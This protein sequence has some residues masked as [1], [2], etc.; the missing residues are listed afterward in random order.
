MVNA[1][2]FATE[3]EAN[4]KKI[5]ALIGLRNYIWSMKS[6]VSDAEG[7]S[8]KLFK[9]EDRKV[10]SALKE[11]DDWFEENSLLADADRFEEKLHELQAVALPILMA[12]YRGAREEYHLLHGDLHK[13]S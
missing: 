13:I 11:T 10:L 3:D 6:Q 8:S 1:E 5:K 2:A 4:R 12:A 9:D 7:L